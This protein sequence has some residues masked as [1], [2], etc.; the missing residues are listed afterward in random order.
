MRKLIDTL[1]LVFLL[2]GPAVVLTC[3]RQPDTPNEK[4][5]KVDLPTN[6]LNLTL[7]YDDS[8]VYMGIRP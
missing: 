4:M 3:V 8:D 6:N 1:V 7:A 5:S 2:V